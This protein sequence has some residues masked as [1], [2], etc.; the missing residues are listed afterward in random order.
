MSCKK[1]KKS[2]NIAFSSL[3]SKLHSTFLCFVRIDSSNAMQC[4][5]MLCACV[6]FCIICGAHFNMQLY[7]SNVTILWYKGIEMVF[8]LE[9][10][11]TFLL[12]FDL[13]IIVIGC[14][15]ELY[16][17]N[18]NM[19]TSSIVLAKERSGVAHRTMDNLH[20]YRHFMNSLH[21]SV[22]RYFFFIASVCNYILRLVH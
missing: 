14:R 22:S 18:A 6:Y 17:S 15:L 19:N 3:F 10:W 1:K 9:S 2:S 7:F 12:S 20:F 16:F 5:A 8:D 13:M 21:V 4:N 11:Q